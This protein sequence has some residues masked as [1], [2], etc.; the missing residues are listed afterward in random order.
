MTT[1][2]HVRTSRFPGGGWHIEHLV[3]GQHWRMCQLPGLDGRYATRY[4]AL[5]AILLWGRN[6]LL[7]LHPSSEPRIRKS[8]ADPRRAA[9]RR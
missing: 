7:L 9:T 2:H 1:T 8:E 3:E 6:D 4:E 5:S